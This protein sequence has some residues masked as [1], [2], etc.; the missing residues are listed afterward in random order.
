MALA[1]PGTPEWGAAFDYLSRHPDTAQAM[2]ETFQ[3]TLEQMGIAP[4]GT[5][6]Q[7]GDP[8]YS[9]NDVARAMGVSEADLD[10]SVEQ[11]R[12]RDN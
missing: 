8:V 10:I 5:D 3:E 7:T 1:T 6:P 11:A 2:L 9:L 12:Q 4:T